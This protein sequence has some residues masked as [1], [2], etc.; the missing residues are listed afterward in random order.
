MLFCSYFSLKSLSTLLVL[1]ILTTPA[2]DFFYYMVPV[3]WMDVTY[4]LWG[5]SFSGFAYVFPIAGKKSDIKI[6]WLN[7]FLVQLMH[8]SHI[9]HT[10]CRPGCKCHTC[11]LLF[12]NLNTET[13]LNKQC[14]ENVIWDGKSKMQIKL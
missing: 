10:F 13:I 1:L 6:V 5:R 9:F 2:E 4:P 7:I 14:K 3:L 12:K 8:F 11:K